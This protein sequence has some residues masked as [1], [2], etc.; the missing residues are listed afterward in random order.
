V[1]A[2][3]VALTATPVT[4]VLGDA[5]KGVLLDA[6]GPRRVAVTTAPM[7]AAIARSPR[8]SGVSDAL[9]AMPPR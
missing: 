2:T 5:T 6:D 1:V 8:R 7:T 9:V 3:L 4:G